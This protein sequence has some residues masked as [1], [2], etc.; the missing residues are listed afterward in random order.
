MKEYQEILNR[1]EKSD[2][3]LKSLIKEFISDI[4]M[5]RLY[6]ERAEEERREYKTLKMVV[7]YGLAGIGFLFIVLLISSF[8]FNI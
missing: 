1:I 3:S 8:I 7:L 4:K 5:I 2:E 6:S